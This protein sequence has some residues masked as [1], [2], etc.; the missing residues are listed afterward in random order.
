MIDTAVRTLGHNMS[1][2]AT[3]EI[4]EKKAAGNNSADSLKSRI[5]GAWTDGITDGATFDIKDKTVYY[6]DEGSDFK[7]FLKGDVITIKYPEYLYKAK[8]SFQSDTLIMDSEEY[9]QTKFWK[10]KD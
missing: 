7:Y 6:V 2:Y 10:L 5:Q 3:T 8:L 1:N 9:G 4:I